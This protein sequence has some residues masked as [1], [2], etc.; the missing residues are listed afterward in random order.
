MTRTEFIKACAGGCLAVAGFSIFSEASAATHYALQQEDAKKIA[1][2]KKE[3]RE[4][5]RRRGY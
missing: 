5:K 4:K 1:L 3:I 2:P